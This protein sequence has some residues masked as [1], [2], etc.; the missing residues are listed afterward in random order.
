MLQTTQM[1][2]KKFNEVMKEVLK[3]VVNLLPTQ[4]CIRIIADGAGG[5]SA[6]KG[7][8]IGLERALRD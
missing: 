5:Y 2:R 1:D 3:S 7:G 6:G 4:E 8:Q